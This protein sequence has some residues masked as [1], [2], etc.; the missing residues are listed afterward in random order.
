M[1]ACTHW[2]EARR[3]RPLDHHPLVVVVVVVGVVVVV[4][5]VTDL[6]SRKNH[7]T[8]IGINLLFFLI[9]WCE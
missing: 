3:L 2:F 7:R 6:V 9:D 8:V 1:R 5:G 4:V